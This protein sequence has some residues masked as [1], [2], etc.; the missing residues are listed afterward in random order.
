MTTSSTD[1]PITVLRA[2]AASLE[3]AGQAI[4]EVHERSLDDDALLRFLSDPACYL[5][6]A[7]DGVR[8]AGSLN[9]YALRSSHR[10]EPRF[11]LYEI[12]VRS[13]HRNRGVGSAL[14]MRFIDEARSARAFKV[15]AVTSESNSAA[16]A[17]YQKCGFA[18]QHF[19]RRNAEPG[20]IGVMNS[21]DPDWKT[22]ESENGG[23]SVRS[24]TFI[25][26]GWNSRAY[27]VNNEFVFRFPKRAEHWEELNREIAFLAFAAGRLPLAVPRY[28]QVVSRSRAAKYGYAAYQYL[29]GHSMDVSVL[30]PKKRAETA[31]RIA[32][33][34]RSMHHLQPGPD[35]ASVL[36]R[37]DPREVAETYLAL[38]ERKVIP[39]L[40]VPEARV[41][42][43]TFNSYLRTSENFTFPPVVLHADLARDHLLVQD[44]SVVGV[45]DF[46]DVNWGDADYDFMYLFV[47]FGPAFAHDVAR[48]YGHPTPE[49]LAFKLRYF[50]VVDQIGTVLDGEGLAL[51]GQS[52]LAWRRLKQLLRDG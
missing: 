31:G 26:E 14:V 17:L 38:A 3:L 39:Q 5:L 20:S 30:T 42:R 28:T 33:F 41:L 32:A 35:V 45:L 10:R 36:P 50:A 11:L 51:Q 22:I 21:T 34:L 4:L 24:A 44:G 7:V 13:T 27:L 48:E 47:D 1:L 49:R 8:V 9:G 29:P 43:E 25:G 46:G 12:D 15:W 37:E 52:E 23:L 16:M 2:N 6:L 18:R 40:A 19:R